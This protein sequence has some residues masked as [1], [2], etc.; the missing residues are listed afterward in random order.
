MMRDFMPARDHGIAF[1]RPAL[2]GEAGDEPGRWDAARFEE[3]KNAA[4]GQR[5]ELAAR[6]RRRRGHAARDEAGMGVEVEAEADDMARHG[7]SRGQDWVP[8]EYN[9][10][11]GHEDDRHHPPWRDRAY[12]LDAAPQE[13]ARADPRRRRARGRR[14]PH[15]AAAPAGR[16]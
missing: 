8:G 5:T 12:L 3:I 4:R 7:V 6:E 1:P 9:I 11:H 10:A 14:R 13:C 2:D 15:R 16:P